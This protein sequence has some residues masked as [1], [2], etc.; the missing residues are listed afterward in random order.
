M[1]GF[2]EID[3]RWRRAGGGKL[4]AIQGP[5]LV[6]MQER[7]NAPA[8]QRGGRHSR[9]ISSPLRDQVP[10]FHIISCLYRIRLT[11]ISVRRANAISAQRTDSNPPIP[12]HDGRNNASL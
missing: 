6:L 9:L 5:A 10:R 8:N 11:D 3:G 2:E 1:G 4:G 7:A 12:R